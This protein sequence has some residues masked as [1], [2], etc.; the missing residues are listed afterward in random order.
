M[1]HRHLDILHQLARRLREVND[2]HLSQI[3]HFSG[4]SLKCT[5][6][7]FNIAPSTLLSVFLIPPLSNRDGGDV[8]S[9]WYI[10]CSISNGSF[11]VQLILMKRSVGFITVSWPL[12]VT[13]SFDLEIEITDLFCSVL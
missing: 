5:V 12:T 8:E 1:H 7:D 10:N 9:F 3:L 6:L 2:H 13:L 11:M 4:G